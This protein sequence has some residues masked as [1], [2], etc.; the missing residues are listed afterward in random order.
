MYSNIEKCKNFNN[1]NIY[2]QSTE[3][4][5]TGKKIHPVLFGDVSNV[6]GQ[7]ERSSGYRRDVLATVKNI[8]AHAVTSTASICPPSI[9]S[10]YPKMHWYA[11][12]VRHAR[13]A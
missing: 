1:I 4:K 5:A 9:G 2:T 7:A 11:A 3:T 8:V 6:L 10:T 13:I 12:L